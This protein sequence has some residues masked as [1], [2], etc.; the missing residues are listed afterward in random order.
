MRINLKG[1]TP[2]LVKSLLFIVTTVTATAVLAI[3]IASTG[4]GNADRYHARFKDVAGLNVGDSVRIAG[5]RVGQI[6]GIRVVDRRVARVDF[7]VERGRRL[8]AST[9][10]QIKYLNLVGQRFVELDRGTGAV[11]GTLPRG[12]TIPLERTTPALNLTQLFAGF[13]PLFQALSPTDV[14]KLSTEIVQVL[15]GESSTMESLLRTVGSLTSHLASKDRV[16]GQTIDNLT[17]VVETINARGDRLD[18]LVVTLQ[19]FTSGLAADRKP[20]GEAIGAMGD[21]A[22]ST[23]GLLR[24]ERAPL[25][26]SVHELGR[27]GTVLDKDKTLVE[28]FLQRLPDKSRSIARLGSYGSW[29]NLYLCEARLSGA[30]YTDGRPPPTGIPNTSARCAK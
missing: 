16:I 8:P 21:L 29:L 12:A 1:S 23:A 10:A 4:V 9:T 7:T 28:Q 2:T 6:T 30:K 20:L 25:K 22:T 26:A 17:E 19:R 3:S 13:Q 24:L 27:L 5:V 15:Q 18:D 11:A 14:N